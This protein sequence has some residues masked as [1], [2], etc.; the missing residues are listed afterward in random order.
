[1][2][3][4]LKC[5]RITERV[6]P[7]KKVKDLKLAIDPITLTKGDLYDI[8][9]MVCDVTNEALY[10]FMQEHQT[11]LGALKVQQY[12]ENRLRSRLT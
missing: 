1:M 11:M 7:R 10:E 4:Q 8:G 9:K 2:C 12:R 5:P 3:T 6:G